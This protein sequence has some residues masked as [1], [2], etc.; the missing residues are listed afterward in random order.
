MRLAPAPP[1]VRRLVNGAKT[2]P[3]PSIQHRNPPHPPVPFRTNAAQQPAAHTAAPSPPAPRPITSAQVLSP[4]PPPPAPTSGPY[5]SLRPLHLPPRWRSSPLP[6]VLRRPSRAHWDAEH[7]NQ[8]PS[9]TPAWPA[10][11]PP[12]LCLRAPLHLLPPASAPCAAA[13]LFRPVT[14]PAWRGS[15]RALPGWRPAGARGRRTG[16]RSWCPR[17][18]S[19]RGTPPR[20][21]RCCPG[22]CTPRGPGCRSPC[23]PGS[24]RIN[25]QNKSTTEQSLPR[26][27]LAGP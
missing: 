1:L 11:V 4:I 3:H 6:T 18:R 25:K 9:G 26:L 7:D 16:W 12:P 2:T 10:W 17:R 24:C 5:T 23:S 22:C 15:S 13:R 14:S 19:G 20:R 21:R 8:L 27:Q